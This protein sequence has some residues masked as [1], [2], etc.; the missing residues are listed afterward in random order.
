MQGLKP[1]HLAPQPHCTVAPDTDWGLSR[2]L[3]YACHNY[4]QSLD[5]DVHTRFLEKDWGL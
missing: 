3:H 5:N 2:V 1:T 4:R